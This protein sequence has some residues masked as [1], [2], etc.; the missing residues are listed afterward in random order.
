MKMKKYIA[1]LLALIICCTSGST[2]LTVN[3]ATNL[4]CTSEQYYMED[5]TFV[6]K[7]SFE[8]N[9]EYA[10]VIKRTYVD[11]TYDVEAING[12]TSV[13]FEKTVV[14]DAYNMPVRPF[15]SQDVTYPHY[16]DYWAAGH[17]DYT[18]NEGTI[19]VAVLAGLVASYLGVAPELSITIAKEIYD[20]LGGD[21]SSKLYFRTYKYYATLDNGPGLPTIWYSKFVTY[22][23]TDPDRT[24]QKGSPVTTIYEGA[25]PM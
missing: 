17:Y 20:G 21:L 4:D 5:G 1:I 8:E 11:G 22:T 13:K 16:T 23:Y 25:F 7:V 14:A 19:T 15:A 2:L 6:E 12:D 9:G 3:A 10:A 18:K 24:I